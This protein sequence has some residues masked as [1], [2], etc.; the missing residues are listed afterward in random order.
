[1]NLVSVKIIPIP[2]L[3]LQV[4]FTTSQKLLI[5]CLTYYKLPPVVV[6]T[7]SPPESLGGCP[8]PY[9]SRRPTASLSCSLSCYDTFS[10]NI[11]RSV[12]LEVGGYRSGKESPPSSK[13]QS[14]LLAPPRYL[15]LAIHK[16]AKNHFHFQCHISGKVFE[17]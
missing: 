6:A 9:S 11:F 7:P 10:S 2:H 15:Y 1:M 3:Y 14:T 17:T 16:I 8:P 4:S 5:G 13:K 12:G